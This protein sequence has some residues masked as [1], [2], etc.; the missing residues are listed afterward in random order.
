MTS[1]SLHVKSWQE[2]YYALAYKNV[3]PKSE[4]TRKLKCIM[5]HKISRNTNKL[6]YQLQESLEHGSKLSSSTNKWNLLEYSK[7][8]LLQDFS[9]IHHSKQWFWSF[10]LHKPRVVQ[11]SLWSEIIG[12]H[13]SEDVNDSL[14]DCN[15]MWICTWKTSIDSLWMSE[16]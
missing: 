7:F 12:S 10:V 9:I 5:R 1:R 16:K 11:S 15:A 2:L 3:Q 6:Q 4:G 13:S 14:T 8:P